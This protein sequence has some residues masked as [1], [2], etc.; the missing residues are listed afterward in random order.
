M[1][2]LSKDYRSYVAHL[3]GKTVGG[4]DWSAVIPFT[5]GKRITYTLFEN[6]KSDYRIVIG[7]EASDSERWAAG[8]LQHWLK[9]VGGVELP[10]E[11]EPQ[12]LSPNSIVVGYNSFSKEL[13]EKKL[14]ATLCGGLI[15]AGL[16]AQ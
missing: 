15:E 2:V 13:L 5:A 16:C 1:G 10:L 4:A 14:P 7:K 11:T 3:S 6:E 9:E 12:E 8:E